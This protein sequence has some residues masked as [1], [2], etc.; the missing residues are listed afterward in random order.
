MP[1]ANGSESARAEE[2][3]ELGLFCIIQVKLRVAFSTDSALMGP[4]RRI[5]RRCFRSI[6]H[7]LVFTVNH[8]LRTIG[9]FHLLV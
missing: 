4:T 7:P 6:L 3:S 5:R 1:R 2:S 9:Y 8:E